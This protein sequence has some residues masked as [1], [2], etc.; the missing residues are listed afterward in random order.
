MFMSFDYN[1]EHV[2]ELILPTSGSKF[3]F[4]K[5]ISHV[6]SSE[7]PYIHNSPLES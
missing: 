1:S 7:A 4:P 3:I 2:L 6:V 5:S